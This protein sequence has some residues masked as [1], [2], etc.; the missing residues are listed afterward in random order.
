M[1]EWLTVI[2]EHVIV[3][4]DAMALIT[5]VIGT[6][7]AFL[8]GLWGILS[9]RDGHWRRDVWLRYARWLVAGLSFLLAADIVETVIVPSWD[10]VVRL[11]V[12]ALIRTSLEIVL[13][14]DLAELRERQREPASV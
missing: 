1:R 10:D 4:I 11:G 9:S 7:E 3:V 6:T 12:I 14:R 13:E 5:V 8:S 2:S